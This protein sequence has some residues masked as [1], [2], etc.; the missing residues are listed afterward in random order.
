MSSD[1]SIAQFRYLERLLLV[2]GHWCYIRIA[3]MVKLS[4]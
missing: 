2:H 1:F 4:S 3:I